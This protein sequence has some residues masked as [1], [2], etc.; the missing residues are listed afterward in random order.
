MTEGPAPRVLVAGIGN[1]FRTDDGWGPAVVRRLAAEPWPEGVRV[2]DYGIRGLHLAYDLL[3]PWDVVVL[4]DALPDRGAIGA[5]AVLAV[6]PDDLGPGA[7]VDA[8]GMDPATVLASLAALGGRMPA[9]TLVVGCQVADTADG[10][11]LTP[12]VAAA[13]GI[14]VDRVRAVVEGQLAEVA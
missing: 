4:V 1:V 6:D 8:H 11:G 2:T 5:V 13:V 12:S 10:M 9:R 7:Q 3:E 14:A